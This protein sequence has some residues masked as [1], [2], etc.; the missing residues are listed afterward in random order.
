MLKQLEELGF[1]DS[2]DG[3]LNEEEKI[4][5]LHIYKSK[6]IQNRRSWSK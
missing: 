6:F 2:T 1:I 4:L 3:Q 5:L